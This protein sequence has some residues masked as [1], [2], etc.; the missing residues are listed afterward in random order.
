MKKDYAK[1]GILTNPRID[2]VNNVKMYLDNGFELVEKNKDHVVFKKNRY[3]NIL[4]YLLLFSTIMI[5]EF[6]LGQ[7][8][9]PYIAKSL[10]YFFYLISTYLLFYIFKSGGFTYLKLHDEKDFVEQTIIENR[11]ERENREEVDSLSLDMVDRR[12]RKEIDVQGQIRR[13][14]ELFQDG[15]I[16]EEEFSFKK[17]KMMGLE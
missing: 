9:D 8:T 7:E 2:N 10:T 4:V 6:F 17:K 12:K 3:Y 13:Y 11:E 14:Y 16:T 1:D 15:I 5:I